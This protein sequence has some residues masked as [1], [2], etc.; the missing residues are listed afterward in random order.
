M[1]VLE[2]KIVNGMILHRKEDGLWRDKYGTIWGFQDG[3]ASIDPDNVCG[4]GAI[5]LSTENTLNAACFVHD[6]AYSNPTYQTFHSREEVDQQLY[7]SLKKAGAGKLLSD[8]FY[9]LAR[10]FGRFFWEKKETR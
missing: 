7:I 6:Q 8:M 3:T 5:S 9:K 2:T 4:V 10:V 1:T